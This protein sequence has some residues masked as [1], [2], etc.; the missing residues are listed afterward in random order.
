MSLPSEQTAQA[1]SGLQSKRVGIPTVLEKI[2]QPKVDGLSPISFYLRLP[3]GAKDGTKLSGVIAYCTWVSDR[4]SLMQQLLYD[5]DRP[6]DQL[7]IPAVQMLKYAS[8]NN[9]AVL[10]WSTP[11]KW[12]AAKSSDELARK[13]L[14]K[15]DDMFDDYAVMWEKGV[16][17]FVKDTG[18]PESDYLLYG[19]SRGAQWAHRLALRKPERFWAINIHVNSSYD[20]PTAIGSECLWL[21][22]TG[23]LEHG[24][25]GGKRFYAQSMAL[26]YPMIF[27]AQEKLGH[28]S[29]MEVETLRDLFFDLPGKNQRT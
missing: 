19:F 16:A 13:E 6:E 27:K 15:V 18:I 25:A 4:K 9:L 20:I 22:T 11:G 21:V 26:G 23:D 1:W 29:C 17:E 24:Y 3:P 14:K 8:E 5:T 7:R 2:I 10:T 28:S 12:S